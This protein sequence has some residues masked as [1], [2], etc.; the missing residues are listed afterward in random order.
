MAETHVLTPILPC[1]DVAVSKAFYMTLGFTVYHEDGEYVIFGHPSGATL[2]LQKAVE[3]WLIPGR[4]PFGMYLY[5]EN[6]DEIAAIVGVTAEDKPWGMYE[7]A[8]SDPDETLIRAGWPTSTASS[9]SNR[10]A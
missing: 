9:W 5:V 8:F 7:V 2:H 10:A 4:N 1:N 6:V 3:G